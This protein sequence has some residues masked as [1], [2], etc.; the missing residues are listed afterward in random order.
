LAGTP[1]FKTG[2]L[3]H[4]ATLPIW[5]F[6]SLTR[7]SY[8]TQ[9]ELGPNLDPTNIRLQTTRR[10]KRG[11]AVGPAC[12]DCSIGANEVEPPQLLSQPL[13]GQPKSQSPHRETDQ[14]ADD[15]APIKQHDRH[16][17]CRVPLSSAGEHKEPQDFG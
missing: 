9:R 13:I 10:Y 8:R 16:R 11:E 7:A 15:E 1:V 3:N 4:S 5:E 14:A 2:A 6:Q 17:K 12:E